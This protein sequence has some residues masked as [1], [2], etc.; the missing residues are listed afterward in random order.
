MPDLILS[1]AAKCIKK[2]AKGLAKEL[3]YRGE[4]IFD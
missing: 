2:T 3:H 4:I 1:S